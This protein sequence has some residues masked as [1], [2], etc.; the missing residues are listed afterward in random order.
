MP[1][2]SPGTRP[3]RPGLTL[4]LA[5]T[6]GLVL[7]LVPMDLPIGLGDGSA[8]AG[9][10]DDSGRGGGNGSGDGRRGSRGEGRGGS[11]TAGGGRGGAVGAAG[12]S[13][14]RRPEPGEDAAGA[15][16]DT[17]TGED[18]NLGPGTQA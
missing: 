7:A 1:F 6:A 13:V 2:F 4:L 3:R 16:D 18:A 8:W 12:L 15:D 5:A 17:P 10:G 11:D 14:D 9:R